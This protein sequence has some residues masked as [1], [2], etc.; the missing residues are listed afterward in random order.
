MVGLS[1]RFLRPNDAWDAN[2]Q[3]SRPLLCLND[4]DCVVVVVMVVVLTRN[5]YINAEISCLVFKNLKQD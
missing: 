4:D 5:T 2:V 3:C 1:Y